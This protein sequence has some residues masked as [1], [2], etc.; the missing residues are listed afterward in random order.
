MRINFSRLIAEK[1]QGESLAKTLINNKSPLCRDDQ[2]KRYLDSSPYKYMPEFEGETD[3]TT[4]FAF[5]DKKPVSLPKSIMYSELHR[6]RD[7]PVEVEDILLNSTDEH[8]TNSLKYF[9]RG[10]Y[11]DFI[12]RNKQF[13]QSIPKYVTENYPL[14]IE[15]ID[16]SY[17]KLFRNFDPTRIYPMKAVIT[18]P[19]TYSLLKKYTQCK[20]TFKPNRLYL[21][22]LRPSEVDAPMMR[23]S[24][25]DAPMI[26]G[27]ELT[28]LLSGIKNAKRHD[29]DYYAHVF[30]NESSQVIECALEVF[31]EETTIMLVNRCKYISD[32]AYRLV[33]KYIDFN[34]FNPRIVSDTN[35]YTKFHA[36]H[37]SL[38]YINALNYI[39]NYTPM[40][41]LSKTVIK[42]MEL[43]D[44]IFEL[45]VIFDR[46]CAMIWYLIQKAVKHCKTN[47]MLT[48]F[49]IRAMLELVF[50]RWSVNFDIEIN[51]NKF[52][53]INKIKTLIE[54]DLYLSR[55][56]TKLICKKQR[57][58]NIGHIKLLLSN[59]EIGTFSEHSCNKSDC[60]LRNIHGSLTKRVQLGK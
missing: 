35:L 45:H 31:D 47:L 12:I 60:V 59:T 25:V 6:L 33:F 51:N 10:I 4:D 16:R 9:P 30:S 56:A 2:V 34:K 39:S 3:V 49:S 18:N 46:A 32:A 11:N 55:W 26:N 19:I 28:K 52:A 27:G 44:V 22:Y 14:L 15:L 54:N 23:P 42:N 53:Y 20:F 43:N 21:R 37:S 7:N 29:L 5:R 50:L 17:N 13:R 48:N 24:E 57:Y 38:G 58:H 8:L 40:G 41:N 1:V 36:Y